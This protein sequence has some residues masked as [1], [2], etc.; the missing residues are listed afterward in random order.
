V[1]TRFLVGRTEGK[2][3]LGRPRLRW[4]DNIMMDL[5]KIGYDGTNWI[6]LAKDK[7]LWRDFVSTVM[8]LR[9]P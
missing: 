5:R 6:W 8:N 9:V 3:P 4:E 1:F 7:I 2:R